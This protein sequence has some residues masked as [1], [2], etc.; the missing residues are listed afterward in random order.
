MKKA[1]FLGILCIPIKGKRA[2]WNKSE[3][4]APDKSWKPQDYRTYK[5]SVQEWGFYSVKGLALGAGA[6]WLFYRSFF[7]LILCIP[8]MVLMVRRGQKKMQ[9][10]RKER[11]ARQFRDSL[12]SLASALS[13]GYSVENAV[14]EA[15]KEMI[16]VYGREGMIVEELEFLNRKLRMNCPV[17]QAF[18]DLAA[19]SGLDEIRQLADVFAIAKRSGGDLVKI[20]NRTAETLRS[21]ARMKEE[22]RTIMAGKRL[23]QKIMSGMPAAMLLYVSIGNPGFTDPL[24][25]GILGRTVMSG[26]LLVYGLAVFW[27]ERIIGRTLEGES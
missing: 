21:E 13:A 7:A 19:R 1:E 2:V 23:E 20:L 16:S 8:F 26:C 4:S 14:E 18:A 25:Q 22:I 12:T 27:G 5:L 6:A 24:Y 10:N 15:K 11:L 3:S 17:E 9:S